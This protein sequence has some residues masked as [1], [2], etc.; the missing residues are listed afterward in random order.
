MKRKFGAGLFWAVV[1]LGVL[2][3][4]DEPRFT[5]RGT[6]GGTAGGTVYLENIGVSR[7]TLLD[8]A[9]LKNGSFSFRYDRPASPDFYRLRFGNQSINLVIDS[10]ETVVVTA[11]SARFAR[12]YTFNAEATECLKI[13]E[14]TLVQLDIA[15]RYRTLQKQYD[16]GDIS[17]DDYYAGVS[18]LAAQ[19]KAA[20]TP[21]I[22]E[23]FAAPK[24]YFALFQQVGGQMIFDIYDKND[25]KLFGAVANAWHTKRPDALRTEQL[26][27]WYAQSRA[28]LRPRPAA[29]DVE[30]TDAK[31]YFEIS[32]PG[33]DGQEVALSQVAQGHITLID[34]TAYAAENSPAHNLYL[35]DLYSQ[36]QAKGLEIYQ[37]SLDSDIHFWKN[38]AANL[39][40]RCVRDVQSIY[41]PTAKKYNVTQI[42]ALFLLN[43]QGEIVE[44][45]ENQ[46]QLVDMLK[47]Y[48]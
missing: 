48:F 23:D 5:V 31:A 15:L 6:I 34:F 38:I 32:L 19:Y 25:S 18:A 16:A 1:C 35:A 26:V 44:R 20:A 42:P 10:T 45:I 28:A 13:K 30:E 22:T 36:Y 41:S 8:S 24:A 4:A 21:Y 9:K 3:C 2:S 33:M 12:D 43:R 29:I 17:L 11:D 40:W 47:K 37:I 27:S 46:T 7:I 39:P 14:L